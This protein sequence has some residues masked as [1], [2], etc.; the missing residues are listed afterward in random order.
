MT[1]RVVTMI[2]EVSIGPGKRYRL[3]THTATALRDLAALPD[4]GKAN[5]R[6]ARA[7]VR[8]GLATPLD[9]IRRRDWLKLPQD[10]RT[11]QGVVTLNPTV[12]CE[13]NPY[14]HAGFAVG[15][16]ITMLGRRVL[17]EIEASGID[18]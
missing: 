1:V 17:K 12:T 3:S 2:V 8:Q 15:F 13:R 14:G 7:L 9:I 6:S 11:A 10:Q 18:L 4:G 5:G 16:R